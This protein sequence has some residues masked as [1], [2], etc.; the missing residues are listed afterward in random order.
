LTEAIDI[1]ERIP[2][3]RALDCGSLANAGPVE[4]FTAVLLQLNA[5]YRSRTSVLITGIDP[6]DDGTAPA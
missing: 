1:I 3:L 4:A 6:D 2:N 5:R